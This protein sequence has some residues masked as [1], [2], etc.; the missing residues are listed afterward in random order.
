MIE[1]NPEAL[2]PI[3]KILTSRLRST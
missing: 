2:M 3:L 1:K